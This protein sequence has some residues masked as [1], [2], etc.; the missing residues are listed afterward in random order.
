MPETRTKHFETVQ[1]DE[2]AVL[3]FPTGI[4]AFEN[5]RRFVLLE[6]SATAPV[7]FLQSLDDDQVCLLAVP[8]QAIDP[9]YELEVAPD[10][11]DTLQADS[12]EQ[13][14]EAQELACLAVIAVPDS[15]A[16]TANLAAP[17]VMNLQTRRGVQ[18]VRGDTRYSFAYPIAP[19]GGPETRQ[20][21][22]C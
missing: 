5:H 13:L 6:R 17:V 9:H 3:S 14:A 7:V 10:D 18:A 22:S 11:L 20:A 16:V 4:P 12:L 21:P 15:G 19:A 8:V 1:Y 2:A